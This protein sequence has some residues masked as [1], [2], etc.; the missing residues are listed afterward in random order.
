ML[1]LTGY[2]RRSITNSMGKDTQQVLDELLTHLI[3]PLLLPYPNYDSQFTLFTDASSYGT[4]CV[5]VEAPPPHLI[6]REG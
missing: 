1:A 2:F 6:K 4:G 3:T 5:I